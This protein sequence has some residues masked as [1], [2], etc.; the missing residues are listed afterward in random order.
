MKRM[1]TLNTPY[2]K[3]NTPYGYRLRLS[4]SVDPVAC[5]KTE[6][7]TTQWEIQHQNLNA[8]NVASGDAE[9]E[10]VHVLILKELRT[11]QNTIN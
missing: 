11:Y 7:G 9:K 2:T 4:S 3:E 10:R 5:G 8:P 1:F 6:G